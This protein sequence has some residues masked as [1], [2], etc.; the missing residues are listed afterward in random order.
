M[1]LEQLEG[2]SLPSVGFAFSE[3]KLYKI[4]DGE[5]VSFTRPFPG[6]EGGADLDNDGASLVIGVANGPPHVKVFDLASLEERS[7]FYAYAP[8]FLGGVNV[9]IADNRLAT[10]PRIGPPH[11]KEFTLAG[12]ET[13][14]IYIGPQTSMAGAVP[15]LPKGV[16]QE[17]FQSKPSATNVLNI[18]FGPDVP[19]FIQQTVLSYVSNYFSNFNLN[20]TNTSPAYSGLAAYRVIVGGSA[21]DYDLRLALPESSRGV[22]DPLAK[23]RATQFTTNTSYVFAAELDYDAIQVAN[24]ITHEAIHQITGRFQHSEDPLSVFNASVSPRIGYIDAVTASNL[25]VALGV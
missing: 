9:A 4:A 16:A 5:V 21:T 1:K 14:S 23:F 2:R 3:G 17:D 19:K 18:G 11:Y 10:G 25:S 7:S 8:E 24:A 15:S 6:Y 20:V 22:S 13:L 12:E